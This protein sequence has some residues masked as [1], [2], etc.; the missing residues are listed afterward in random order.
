MTQTL[1]VGHSFK[2]GDYKVFKNLKENMHIMQEIGG[3]SEK[4][5]TSYKV[6]IKNTRND[7]FHQ[8]LKKRLDTAE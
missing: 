8:W 2:N 5:N 6:S 7:N 1:E 4:R 3:K